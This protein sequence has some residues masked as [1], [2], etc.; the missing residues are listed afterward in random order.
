MRMFH[1]HPHSNATGPAGNEPREPVATPPPNNRQASLSLSGLF[2]Q[3]QIWPNHSGVPSLP[4]CSCDCFHHRP[5][6]HAVCRDLDTHDNRIIKTVTF[7]RFSSCPL[8]TRRRA[9]TCCALCVFCVFCLPPANTQRQ[10]P[11]PPPQLLITT[12]FIRRD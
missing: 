1:L 3:I 6:F 4:S 5:P 8:K 9:R 7:I 2:I 12:H 10:P 11:P